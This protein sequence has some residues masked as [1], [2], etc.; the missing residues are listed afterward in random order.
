MTVGM[1]A[2]A[3]S[4]LPALA[5]DEPRLRVVHLTTSYP[6]HEGDFAGRFVADLVRGLA[7]HVDVSVLAPGGYRD[8]GLAY[9]R[10]I[11][12]N[13]RRRPWLAPLLLA[14]MILA[15]RRA[16]GRR[17][18]VHAH[19]LAA[20][21]ICVLARR[22]FVLTLHG[23]GTAGRFADLELARRH[24]RL[25]RFV[26]RRAEVVI[27]VSEVLAEA[28][29]RCG[30]R[31]VRTIPNG[32]DLPTRIGAEAEL[33]E[34]LFV[35]RLSPEKGIAE[36]VAAT[37]GL[38]LVVAGDGPLRHLVPEAL[39]FV[40]HEELGELYDRAAVVVCP[41]YR[42]GLPLCVLEAMAHGRPV[43]ASAVGGIP[44]LVEDG[45]TGFLVEPGD[46][47]GLRAAIER[48]L[49]DPV[50]RR[51]LGCAARA[52]VAERCSWDRVTAAT[53]AAY[54]GSAQT[55]MPSLQY[56]ASRPAA[57][58]VARARLAAW[59]TRNGRRPSPRPTSRRGLR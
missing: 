8:F 48:L 27:G 55:T 37:P 1:E 6:R 17:D 28:A 45:V 57:P 18:L 44:E 43:V 52:R 39:G 53:L 25:V 47:A 10:G 5:D 9:G 11:V 31:D 30:G 12:G 4:A 7:G 21:L 15:V 34:V 51:R 40:S 49:A 24:P 46:V 19:W 33:A 22:R 29:R 2:S 50:L 56:G 58:R 23:S 3:A 35:G 41:S 16:A 59:P 36:L 14:S 42:E 32:V 54:E 26:V 38:N 13:L 20:G